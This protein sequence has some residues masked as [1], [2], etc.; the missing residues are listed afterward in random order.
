MTI[1]SE[2]IRL[3]LA[4]TIAFI[5][6]RLISRLKLPAILG[7]LITGIIIGPHALGLLNDGL[8]GSD[9]FNSA[10]SLL[11][12]LFGIMIGSEMIWKQ[13]KRSGPQII[14]TTITESLG[15][16]FV[17][18]AIFG[19]IFYLTDVP[20]YLA[21]IFGGIALATAPAPSLSVV[22]SLK[23]D[24]PVTR[25]LIPMAALD[26]LVGALVFFLVIAFV[27]AHISTVDIPIFLII[28]LVFLPVVIGGIVGFIFSKIMQRTK[29]ASTTLTVMIIGLLLSAVIGHLIN[30]TLDT[31]II[32]FMLIGMSYSIVFANMLEKEKLDAI[33]KVMDPIIGFSMIVVILNLAAPLD[34]H[35]IFSAGLY[36]AIYIIA[37]AIGKYSGA[38]LGAS[39][40]HAPKTVQKYLGLTLLPHSG[41]SLVF[42][43]IAISVL[44]GN[45]PE[46]VPIIQGTIAA[47][48][49]INEIIAVFLARQGFA[50]AGELHKAES[51]S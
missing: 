20:I 48:A 12:C 47:A 36:T 43:G 8:L 22:D 27:S 31:S 5:A 37:R 2:I 21:F 46:C 35:L 10:E 16:F 28:S 41:V 50:W 24:G 51:R 11:E 6:G 33:M 39:L 45:A 13:M 30:S 25:T 3:A 7:W 40:T 29:K 17:V 18:S 44:Q 4:I 9:W 49:V 38:Y 32:N 42:T 34:Y 15:T 26:D 19:I 1:L 23:T 14:V